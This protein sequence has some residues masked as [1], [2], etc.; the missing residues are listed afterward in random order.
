L[1][2]FINTRLDTFL[3]NF[4]TGASQVGLYTTSASVAEMLWFVPNAFGNMVFSKVPGMNPEDA[5]DLVVRACRQSVLVM[6]VVL[7]I[8][9]FAGPILIAT[10]FGPAFS[11]AGRPF[12]W[13]LPGIFGLGISRVLAA[14]FNGRGKPL[15]V[16]LSSLISAGVLL[17]W[18]WH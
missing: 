3:V 9:I 4:F 8:S 2:N 14:D 17:C 6:G 1:L 7:A 16:T 10:I 18:T 5:N 15:F 13:L 11:L 12:L